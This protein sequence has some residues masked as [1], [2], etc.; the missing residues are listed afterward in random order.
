MNAL[1]QQV[2]NNELSLVKIFLGLE[3]EVTIVSRTMKFED[4][5]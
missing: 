5:L 1:R 4:A 2:G 3:K